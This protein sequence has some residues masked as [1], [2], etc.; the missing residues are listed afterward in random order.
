LS[1]K[2]TSETILKI[3][4]YNW[5]IYGQKPSATFFWPTL[6]IMAQP[7]GLNDNSW[8]SQTSPSID[9][10]T[11]GPPIYLLAVSQSACS[12]CCLVPY[13]CC[14]PSADA[15]LLVLKFRPTTDKQTDSEHIPIPQ[16]TQYL[17]TVGKCVQREE[18]KKFRNL[19][20]SACQIY[21]KWTTYTVIRKPLAFIE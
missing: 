11:I 14:Y 3:G 20:L 5:Q 8:A 16:N 1:A 7:Q 12:S 10:P 4:Q 21:P 15:R 6:Y 9:T 13:N 19:K 17:G 2:S 18:Q